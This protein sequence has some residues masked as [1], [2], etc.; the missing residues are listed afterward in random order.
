MLNLFMC[1]AHYL[2]HVYMYKHYFLAPWGVGVLAGMEVGLFSLGGWCPFVEESEDPGAEE[3][4]D[5]TSRS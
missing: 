1:F 4:R 5:A 2:R 3:D